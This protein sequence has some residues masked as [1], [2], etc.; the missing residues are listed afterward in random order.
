MIGKKYVCLYFLQFL[1]CA[2][3]FKV[4]KLQVISRCSEQNI[5]SLF[6]K[7]FQHISSGVANEWHGWT[8][9]RCPGAKGTPEKETKKQRK[10]KRK[11]KMKNRKEKRKRS[12][13]RTKLFKYPDGGPTR[14]KA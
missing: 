7:M 6:D 13:E 10:R 14:S 5:F 9:S 8:M 4:V 2:I 12:K 1:F 3:V 11:K